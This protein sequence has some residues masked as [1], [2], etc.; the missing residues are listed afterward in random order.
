MNK[1]SKLSLVFISSILISKCSSN[2][3]CMKTIVVPQFY[4]VNGQTYSYDRTLE[5]SCDTP[6]IES[7]QEIEPPILD[8]FSYE[9]LSFNFISDTGN[10]T[11]RLQFEIKLYNN[12]DWAVEGIPILTMKADNLE[13]SGSYSNNSKSPCY[14]SRG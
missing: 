14:R 7:P 13:F 4:Y 10:E 1:I 12:N 5:V 9:V 8:S 3:D 6:E 2:D 11:S